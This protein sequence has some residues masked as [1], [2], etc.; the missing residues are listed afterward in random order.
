[1]AEWAGTQGWAVG[2]DGVILRFYGEDWTYH[3]PSFGA[4]KHWLQGLW[5]N[6]TATEGWAVGED[7]EFLRFYDDRWT[8]HVRSGVPSEV[9]SSLPR[10]PRDATNRTR[11]EPMLAIGT[12]NEKLLGRPKPLAGPGSRSASN[13]VPCLCPAK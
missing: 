2:K 12:P 7:G 6:K 5:L 1:M 10:P 4:T 11:P 8:R 9:H 13:T 3:W